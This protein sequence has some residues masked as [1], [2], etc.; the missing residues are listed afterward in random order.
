LHGNCETL[1]WITSLGVT[2]GCEGIIA[3]DQ[4]EPGGGVS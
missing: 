2:S 4:H 3:T 1:S